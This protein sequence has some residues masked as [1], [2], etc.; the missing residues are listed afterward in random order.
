MVMSSQWFCAALA[1]R[2]K[3]NDGDQNE[4]DDDNNHVSIVVISVCFQEGA[5]PGLSG[6]FRRHSKLGALP[7]VHHSIRIA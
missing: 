2:P 7:V 5:S 4:P 6:S 3:R 1:V